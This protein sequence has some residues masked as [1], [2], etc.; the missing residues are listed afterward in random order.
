V[1]KRKYESRLLIE[2]IIFRVFYDIASRIAYALKK[3]IVQS[4]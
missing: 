1:K 3:N 4:S 2:I